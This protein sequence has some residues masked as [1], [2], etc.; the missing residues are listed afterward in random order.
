MATQE[1]RPGGVVVPLNA[2]RGTNG[3]FQDRC[4]IVSTFRSGL[5]QSSSRT[6]VSDPFQARALTLSVSGLKGL[7]PFNSTD[8]ACSMPGFRLISWKRSALYRWREGG[9][10]QKR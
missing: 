2:S 9:C 8:A 7:V 3:E 6:F 4:W 5:P 10:W 1:I